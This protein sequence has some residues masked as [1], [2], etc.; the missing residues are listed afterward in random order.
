MLILNIFDIAHVLPKNKVR[1]VP[2]SYRPL[3]FMLLLW[4]KDVYTTD[5][6]LV[7]IIFVQK[8]KCSPFLKLTPTPRQMPRDVTNISE[9]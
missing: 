2:P 8:G 1:H 6:I 3:A 4:Q 9:D 7:R 5:F